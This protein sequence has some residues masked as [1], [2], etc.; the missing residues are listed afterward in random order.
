MPMNEE[1]SYNHTIDFANLCKL[2][3]IA[4]NNTSYMRSMMF[5]IGGDKEKLKEFKLGIT[6]TMETFKIMRD[7]LPDR[8]PEIVDN[9]S[10]I[11]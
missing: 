8:F 7:H 3:C 5:Y 9:Q 4:E 6:A 1:S 2:I 11:Q 10:Q